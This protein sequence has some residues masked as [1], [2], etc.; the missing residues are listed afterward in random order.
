MRCLPLNY[1]QVLLHYSAATQGN[2]P[3]SG[4]GELRTHQDQPPLPIPHRT[5]A[6][7]RSSEHPANLPFEVLW[8]LEDCNEDDNACPSANNGSRPPMALALHTE[9]G[10]LITNKKFA[11]IRSDVASLCT[12]NLH[13]LP[14]IDASKGRKAAG[15]RTRSWYALWYK[16]ELMKVIEELERMHP[17]LAL[18]GG[19]WKVEHLISNHLNSNNTVSKRRNNP[20]S[21]PRRRQAAEARNQHKSRNSTGSRSPQR[22]K[23]PGLSTTPIGSPKRPR[24]DSASG[25]DNSKRRRTELHKGAGL[26]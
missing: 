21:R 23:S 13:S 5:L 6:K 9:S 14:D 17:I 16:E 4:S 15:P 11:D 3:P 22:P 18:C 2:T 20:T 7:V 19:H 26:L 25:P 1:T 24:S 8:N 12:A 10:D